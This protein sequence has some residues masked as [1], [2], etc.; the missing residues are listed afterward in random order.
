M[1]AAV[2]ILL[3]QPRNGQQPRNCEKMKLFVS[4]A[5]RMMAKILVVELMLCRLLFLRFAVIGPG[6]RTFCRKRL[7]RFFIRGMTSGAVKG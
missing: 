7:Q 6:C 4:T 1:P 2:S 3:E 5:L